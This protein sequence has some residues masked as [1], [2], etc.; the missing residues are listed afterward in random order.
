MHHDGKNIWKDYSTCISM[1]EKSKKKQ[2]FSDCLTLKMETQ[3]PF[4]MSGTVTPT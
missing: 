2:F 3:G 4:K 1:A